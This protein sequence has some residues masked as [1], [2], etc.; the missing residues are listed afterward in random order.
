MATLSTVYSN[1]TVLTA[2]SS[3]NRPG[4]GTP[5]FPAP[6]ADSIEDRIISTVRDL[7]KMP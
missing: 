6:Y 4:M 3:L 1:V 2:A 7:L 5:D